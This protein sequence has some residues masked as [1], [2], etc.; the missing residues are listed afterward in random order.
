MSI[1]ARLIAVLAFMSV[2]LTVCGVIG[3]WGMG[4]SNRGLKHVYDDRVIPLVQL[5]SIDQLLLRNRVALGMPIMRPDDNPA[6]TRDELRERIAEVE[7]NTAEIQRM[8][9]AFSEHAMTPEEQAL[10]EQFHQAFATFSEQ[11]L[12]IALELMRNG[13][14]IPAQIHWVNAVS[15][16]Y[17]PVA[18]SVAKLTEMQIELAR[19]SY[20]SSNTMYGTIRLVALGSIVLG[21]ALAILMG[22][23]LIRAILDP[24]NEA[25]RVANAIAKGDLTNRIVVKSSDETGRMLAAMK[26]MS[27]RLAALVARA[28]EA[29]SSVG[30][31]AREIAAGNMNLSQRTEEQASSLEETAS[32][33]EELTSTVKQNADSARQANQLANA[34]R[35]SAERG[36]EVVAKAVE[37]MG[38]INTSSKKVS[39]IVGV[40]D[41]IAFQTNL[42]ALNAAVEAARAGEQGRG[43]AVVAAEVRNLAQR[44]AA[45]AKEIKSLIGDS[46]KKV[47]DGTEL[48]HH[49][50]QTLAEI[51]AGVKKV[52]DIVAEIAAASQEQA[53]GIEQV[54]RAVMQMDEMTQQ[55][56]A[57]VEQAAAASRSMEE[58]AETLNELMGEFR[59]NGG[60]AVSRSRPAAPP[61]VETT[62]AQSQTRQV[63]RRGA[64]RPWSNPA[65]SAP[66]AAPQADSSTEGVRARAMGNNGGEWEEF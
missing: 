44:S 42:L 4:E 43:F 13:L 63:E 64:D 10:S 7:G 54:N 25:I 50:G 29:S 17:Y 35:E 27:E 23:L 47:N 52:T 33:M 46:V 9:A 55:N 12:G 2:L 61:R 22:V 24:L 39:D 20:E 36:G 53:S 11:G 15:T 8:W 26:E 41:E 65:A 5:T 34:A 49:S 40:I 6:R 66:T 58:Q 31:G 59:I 30:T 28:T 3:L 1:R 19:Q 62:P 32:S 38:D 56:A 45:S 14:I 48:V 18:E 51:V 21:I 60:T 37:A 57:L 16:L